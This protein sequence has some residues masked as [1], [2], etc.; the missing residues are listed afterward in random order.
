MWDGV[1]FL[2]KYFENKLKFYFNI[3][4]VVCFG[5]GR[6]YV[7]VFINIDFVVVSN[8][9]ERNGVIYVFY[10]EFVGYFCVY[11]MIEKYVD[12]VNCL[13]VFEFCMGGVQIKCFLI[14]YKE[15]DVDDG[16]FM[17]IQK[18]CCGFIVD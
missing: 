13:F 9:V 3:K 6:D 12:E 18:V 14:L 2:L 5:D 7:V 15:F 17:C 10:Q 4:E 16:E 8:W 1:F 11:D